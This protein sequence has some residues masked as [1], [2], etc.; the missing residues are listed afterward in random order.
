MNQ[1]EVIRVLL[2]DDDELVRDGLAMVLEQSGGFVVTE[3]AADGARALAALSREVPDVVLLDIRM[4]DMDGLECCRRIKE[5]HPALPVLMLT[6]FQ[7]D[8]YLAGSLEAGSH[9]YLLKHQSAEAVIMAIRN[10]VNGTYSF[11]PGVARSLRVD[12]SARS[13][14]L[15]DELPPR[16]RDVLQLLVEGFS[17]REIAETTHLSEGTVR[18]Y[19]SSLLQFADVRD[20]TQL[21]IWYYR[22]VERR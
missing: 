16:G 7:D 10:A 18:N 19:V 14:S 3:K 5:R 11:G 22:T 17:N 21:V 12:S 4:P 8:E 2:A 15:L 13:A 6:T 1:G 9:G 20:R